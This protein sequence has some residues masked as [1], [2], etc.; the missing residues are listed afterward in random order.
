MPVFDGDIFLDKD[1]PYFN[2]AIHALC[3]D[4]ELS[5]EAECFLAINWYDVS[6]SAMSKNMKCARGT[7]YNRARRF[8]RRAI[9]LAEEIRRQVDSCRED[10]N[11]HNQPV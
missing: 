4:P 3:E 6:I 1:I 8:A 10:A 7:L 5:G 9:A 11:K 2:M